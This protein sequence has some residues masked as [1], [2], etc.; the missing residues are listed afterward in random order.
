MKRALDGSEVDCG[1]YFASMRDEMVIMSF[2]LIRGSG[3]WWRL[4]LMYWPGFL[5]NTERKHDKLCH[6]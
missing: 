2:F 1:S 3:W 5:C 6:G 4:I